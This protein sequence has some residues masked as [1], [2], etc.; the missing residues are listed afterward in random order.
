VET[1]DEVLL[2]EELSSPVVELDVVVLDVLELPEVEILVVVKSGT[3]VEEV[4]DA[5]VEELLV[6]VAELCSPVDELV[7]DELIGQPLLVCAVLQQHAT[8]SYKEGLEQFDGLRVQLETMR[9]YAA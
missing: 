1:S 6:D 7:D 8:G 3:P 5:V 2:A 4:D 9:E